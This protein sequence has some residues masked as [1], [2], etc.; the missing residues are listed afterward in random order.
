LDSDAPPELSGDESGAERAA[1]LPLAG[2][3]ASAATAVQPTAAAKAAAAKASKVSFR[4]MLLRALMESVGISFASLQSHGVWLDV[5]L[6]GTLKAAP[7]VCMRL[8][9]FFPC[10]AFLPE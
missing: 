10:E 4:R 3:Q 5:T 7:L 6:E 2:E 9:T 8:V 1:S